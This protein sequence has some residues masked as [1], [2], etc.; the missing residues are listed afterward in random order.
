MSRALKAV[1]I[2]PA[3]LPSHQQMFRGDRGDTAQGLSSPDPRGA[4]ECPAAEGCWQALVD[5]YVGI[6]SFS[7]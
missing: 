3:L 7:E 1:T 5:R 6:F 4:A 2:S